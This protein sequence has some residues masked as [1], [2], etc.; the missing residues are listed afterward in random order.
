MGG[1]HLQRHLCHVVLWSTQEASLKL[2]GIGRQPG[3]VE[4]CVCAC[5]CK[6]VQS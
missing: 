2:A 1:A 6:E 4:S 3:E 5:T